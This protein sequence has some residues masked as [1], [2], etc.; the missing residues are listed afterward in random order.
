MLLGLMVLL[1][2]C[3]TQSSATIVYVD[4]ANFAG[5]QEGTTWSSAYYSFA[6]GIEY[7][8]PGD[9]IWVAKGTYSPIAGTFFTLKKDVKIFGGFKNTDTAFSQRNFNLNPT[10]LKGNGHGVIRND[11]S[12]LITNTTILDGFTIRNGF[13]DNY[14]PG[15]GMFNNY[16]SPTIL[17]CTF[18]NNS[19]SGYT[20]G[21]GGAM[22]NYNCAPYIAYCKFTSNSAPIF[23]GNP[24]N[25]SGS[26]GG[27]AV[28][29]GNA[30]PEFYR[31]TFSGNT[32]TTGGALFNTDNSHPTISYCTFSSNTVSSVSITARGGAIYNDP[33]T[34]L[35]VD[36][37]AFSFNQAIRG[38]AIFNNAV[39]SSAITRCV[40]RSNNS[41]YGAGV[42]HSY[43]GANVMDSCYFWLNTSYANGAGVYTD[44]SAAAITNS[45]F[46]ANK[47]TDGSGSGSGIFA[48]DSSLVTVANC[49]FTANDGIGMVVMNNQNS[50]VSSVS[51]SR[52]ENEVDG[53]FSVSA[54]R[55]NVTNCVFNQNAGPLSIG[56]GQFTGISE[57]TNC[58]FTNNAS[59]TQGGALAVYYTSPLITGCTFTNNVPAGTPAN[60]Y[61]LGGAIYITGSFNYAAAP[62]ITQCTFT[63]NTAYQGGAIYNTDNAVPIINN[64]TFSNNSATN[65]GGGIWGNANSV[66]NCNFSGNHATGRGGALYDAAYPV[67]QSLFSGNSASTGGGI[68]SNSALTSV[69]NCIFTK[70]AADSLG[71]GMYNNA[72]PAFVTNSTF[73]GNRA[74]LLGGPI[75]NTNYGNYND[76]T[77]TNCIIW[78]N[79]SGIYNQNTAATAFSYS[80]VQGLGTFAAKHILGGTINPQFVDTAAG[81]FQLL[82]S[83]PCINQG[84]NSYIPAGITTDFSNGPRIINSIVDF[85]ALESGNMPLGIDLTSFTGSLQD[86]NTVLLQWKINTD[87]PIRTTLQKSRDGKNFSPVFTETINPGLYHTSF[88]DEQPSD[89][90]FYRLELNY[91]TGKLSYSNTLYIRLNK[92]SSNVLVY[93][94]PAGENIHLITKTS[95]LLNT[96]AGI[97]DIAGKEFL[98][99]VI[100]SADQLISLKDLPKGTYILRLSN[101]QAFKISKL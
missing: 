70:N 63:G 22:A 47:I 32:S 91:E 2:L 9:T 82:S 33:G 54:A 16:A 49:A 65:Q 19:V 26:G 46:E 66:R 20:Y 8:N 52:F 27:G 101:G 44:H 12:L 21:G 74:N 96:S 42:Y 68:Y 29:N 53:S 38:G 89:E 83:S 69:V 23:Y 15:G 24:P 81:N 67:E 94:N 34:T 100:K 30:S 35:N 92:P 13:P 77:F 59:L 80:L 98:R 79:G 58:T 25:A 48:T 39:S 78:G 36:S 57:V 95:G 64:C 51:N 72:P 87:K 97:S 88:P 31:C 41:P 90:N 56:G 85:G 62:T 11:S 99:F 84:K 17:N 61:R 76:S 71:G 37:C 10:I 5:N 75:Y 1:C 14:G 40:F 55:V 60:Y 45:K 3:S 6:Y 43:T 7:A 50:L 18:T 28:A 93:P 4:S 86:D 73:F